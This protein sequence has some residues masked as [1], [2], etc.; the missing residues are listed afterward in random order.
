MTIRHATILLLILSVA[1]LSFAADAS[2][3][4]PYAPV[5]SGY[6]RSADDVLP[7]APDR[8]LVQF[9]ADAYRRSNLAAASVKNVAVPGAKTGLAD[10][11][12]MLAETGVVRL[13][14]ALG[15][16]AG[17]ADRDRLGV[18]RWFRLD[19]AGEADVVAIAARLAAHPDV[20]HANPDWRAFPAVV[21]SD[22]QY[23]DNWGHH[24][25]AQLPG[26]DWGGSWDH[27]LGGVG[28]VGFDTN[29]DLAW[30]YAQG[31]GAPGVVIAILD[32]GV[33]TGH[34]DL[35]LVAGY[36]FGDNDS[37]PDD[38]SAVPGHGTACAGVAAATANNGLGV[39]GIAGG[40]SIMPLKVAD[41]WGD[42]YFSYLIDAI[43][44]AADNGA[45]VIS[46]SLG[47]A[48]S[49]DPSTDAA[50]L[51]ARNA[52]VV[53]LAATGN[54]N[55]N[56]ISYPA[57]N[58]N[59]IAVGAAS[60]CGD[61]KRSSSSSGEVN[62]GV[63]TDPNGYTCDGERWWGSNYGTNTQDAASAVDIIAPTILPTT[64]ITGGGGYSNND[65]EPFF[66]GTSCATPYAAGVAALILSAEPTLTPSQV[67]TRIRSTALDVVN[68]ESGSGWDRYS[69]YGMIDAEAAIAAGAGPVA[70]TADFVG[71]PTGGC[72]PLTVDFTDQSTGDVTSWSWNFGDG[73]VS[74]QQNPP[75][76]YTVAG[77]YSVTLTATGPGGSDGFTRTNY[78]TVDPAPAADFTASVTA[79]FAPLA[80]DFTD[81]SAGGPTSWS[82]TF[83]DGGTS[84]LQSP[85]HTYTAPGV[86]DVTLTAT[87]PCGSDPVTKTG[88]ITVNA[89][90]PTAAFTQDQTAICAGGDVSFTDQSTGDVTS[91]DWDF[92][93]GGTSTQPNPIHTY[94]AAGTFTVSLTVIGPGGSDTA[95]ATNLIDVA[96]L[97]A[98]DFTASVTAG[99]APLAVDFTDLSAGGPTS[100][101]WTFGDGGTSTLQSPQHTYATGGTFAVTLVATGS[102]GPDTMIVADMIVVTIA[103]APVAAFSGDPLMLC[104]PGDVTFTD[105]STGDIAS[106]QWDFGDGNQS[107]AQHPLHTYAAPGV[108]DV[109]LI[110]TGPAG[111]DTLLL[112]GY[113]TVEGPVT[114]D[115]SAS[116]L[117][118]TAPLTVDF[119]DL[120]VG[121]PTS[122]S[123]DFGDA[124]PAGTIQNPS[125]TYTL[126]G[127][128]TISLTAANGC[129]PDTFVL[130]A[131][132]AVTDPPAPVADF[133]GDP[134]SGCA[135]LG[136]TFTDASAGA[137]TAWA[138]DFGD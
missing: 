98:A 17:S 84:T 8:V 96:P 115:A 91:W 60:P 43:Y 78:V 49:G 122:W 2:A 121:I 61:R 137:V 132:I 120:S 65:Y 44:Y 99:F 102:C 95:T 52:G 109:T 63:N 15:G 135:P 130:P 26:Y 133:A 104:A 27:T 72:V 71:S 30:N 112:A 23:A 25:T 18:D 82:W 47:A 16:P 131:Q 56:A 7:Y 4:R 31:Y 119:T 88:Y 103:T 83:G 118:G 6:V 38:N 79:G 94:A 12:A 106:W 138:W 40:C 50:L 34:P 80:V 93:D 29:A 114:A 76:V 22:P 19:L 125:H 33:D 62:P 81:L 87:N 89:A 24:N 69:G 70:P 123:W 28:T 9:T 45:D 58:G 75:H 11:D 127:T 86:Y 67:R 14:K 74:T 111:A 92:G 100:W 32:S 39:A 54:E 128:Y 113:V 3:P 5:Q 41:S 105:A 20:E 110:V 126:A 1:G 101:S 117:S 136:V 57:I 46:M 66:N 73:G 48:I 90:P 85:S 68:V 77:T 37:N 21:P 36:D 55:D 129:G 134:L 53:I 42:I 51:Y 10:M 97:V 107:T 124:S 64:D 108:Y 35:N 59:V 13:A 116:I